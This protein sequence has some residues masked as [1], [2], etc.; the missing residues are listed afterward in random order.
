[1]CF[2][3][4]PEL[5]TTN[6]SAWSRGN[7]VRQGRGV[8]ALVV[9]KKKQQGRGSQI[10]GMRCDGWQ[11]DSAS[12]T[13]PTDV[14]K[15]FKSH[16]CVQTH[17]PNPE[18]DHKNGRYSAEATGVDD[19]Q[20]LCRTSN[21]LKRSV[22]KKCKRDGRRFD[23]TVLGFRKGW[24]EGSE[25]FGDPDNREGCRGCYFHDIKRFVEASH[26]FPSSQEY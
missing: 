26:D 11:D 1:V 25:L 18:L 9:V 10:I 3:K 14:R 8:R 4:H 12:R 15:H 5:K 23:A 22:C 6:G 17:S 7:V 2:E 21:L 16:R 20:P 13:I 19:F 24:I